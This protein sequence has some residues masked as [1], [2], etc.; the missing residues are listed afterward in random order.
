MSLGFT[1]GK[2]LRKILERAP[3]GPPLKRGDDTLPFSVSNPNLTSFGKKDRN[4]IY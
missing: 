1:M 3:P 2:M 4:R